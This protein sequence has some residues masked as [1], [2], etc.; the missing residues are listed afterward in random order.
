MKTT[1]LNFKQ[2]AVVAALFK[3]LAADWAAEQD[4]PPSQP[5]AAFLR[6][7]VIAEARRRYK[8]KGNVYE[9]F[10]KREGAK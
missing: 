4:D 7:L 9:W 1:D 3:R 6:S 10:Q 8:V 5:G 2:P